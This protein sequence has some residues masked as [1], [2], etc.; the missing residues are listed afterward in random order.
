MGDTAVDVVV[1]AGSVDGSG[2][3]ITTVH[4]LD[5]ITNGGKKIESGAGENPKAWKAAM[6][7]HRMEFT[8]HSDIH[9]HAH[10]L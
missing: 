6:T 8:R 9:Q 3:V 5:C 1:Q 4:G 10:E 7:G 2:N